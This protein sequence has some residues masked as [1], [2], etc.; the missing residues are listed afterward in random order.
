M[1]D[2]AL[3]CLHPNTRELAWPEVVNICIKSR[4]TPIIISLFAATLNHLQSHW[5]E[6]IEI[7]KM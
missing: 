3:Q 1:S 4:N 6:K 7:G 5:K 2:I